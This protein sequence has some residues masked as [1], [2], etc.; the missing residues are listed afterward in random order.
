MSFASCSGYFAQG[1]GLPGAPCLGVGYT[2][3]PRVTFRCSATDWVEIMRGQLGG[4]QAIM[5]G[6]L[7]V[8]GNW[9]LALR[10]A[11]MLPVLPNQLPTHSRSI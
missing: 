5:A 2:E 8:K 9:L 10:L 4:R 11:Q 7:R 6:R 3:S 1:L